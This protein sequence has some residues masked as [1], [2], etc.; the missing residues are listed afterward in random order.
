M[1][2]RIVAAHA[3]HEGWLSLELL[4]LELAT[5]ERVV[6]EVVAHPS[7]AAVLA[8][9]PARRVA[10]LVTESRPP[11]LREGA[12]PLLEAIAGALDEDAPD[13]CARREALEEGGLELHDL[14]KVGTV[15]M[16]PSTSTERVH[17]FL[18][19]YAGRDRV[20]EGGGLDEEAEHLRL[21]EVPLA[22]LAALADAG[23]LADAK[24]LLLVQALRLR[25]PALFGE[26]AHR[27]E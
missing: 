5:G 1:P 14:E 12:P 19:A 18:A 13:A 6:R 17:L 16:T 24:T 7:G 26:A 4:T 27:G 15:W 20:A 11:L 3:R 21:H 22:R 9:D 23:E 25:R 10:M 8:Y 2:D